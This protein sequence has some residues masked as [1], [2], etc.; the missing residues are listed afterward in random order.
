M[1]S[2][3]SHDRQDA[4]IL[5]SDSV[6]LVTSMPVISAPAK[7]DPDLL[8]RSI[9][10]VLRLIR[11]DLAMDMVLI[12][13]HVD[14]QVVVS[15]AAAAA[16]E[17]NI[18]GLSHPRELSIC[19]RVLEGRL[20]AVIPDMAALKQ[21]HDVPPTPVAPAAFMA[22]PVVLSCGRHY[23]VLCCLKSTPMPELDER[24]HRR[25]QMSAQHIARLVDEAG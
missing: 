22:V 23:G 5:A 21:T 25:L 9:M 18:E 10:D 1:T 17:C 20:P 16:E 4:E 14:D 12:T 24:H 13:I 7:D 19:Q 6:A 2:H 3:S 8:H 15:H 11:E